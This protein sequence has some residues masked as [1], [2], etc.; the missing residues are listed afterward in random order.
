[1]YPGR[2]QRGCQHAWSFGEAIWNLRNA[3]DQKSLDAALSDA[4]ERLTRR[5]GVKTSFQVEGEVVPLI[6][7]MQHEIIMSTREAIMNALSHAP[8]AFLNV[9]LS[10]DVSAVTVSISNDGVGFDP[11]EV[12]LIESD[13]FGLSGMREQMRKVRGSMTVDSEP[14]KGTKIYLYLPLG[15]ARIRVKQ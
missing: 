3:D 7:R 5:A 11:S 14:G 1:M 8:P 2:Y 4:L 10:F 15:P 9:R 13:H 6:P 12:R